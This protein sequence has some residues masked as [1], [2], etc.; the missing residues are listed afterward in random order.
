MEPVSTPERRPKRPFRRAVVVHG[1][2]VTQRIHT[3]L[4]AFKLALVVFVPACLT[5]PEEPRVPDAEAEPERAPRALAPEPAPVAVPVVPACPGA[6]RIAADGLI[7]DL[8]DGDA[9]VANAAGR[10]GY[11]W[12]AKA[13]HA[14]VT[15]PAGPSDGGAEGSKKAVRFA[16]KTDPK[17]EWGAAVGANFLESGGFY[18]ASKYAG[19]AFKIKASKPNTSVRVKLPDVSTIPDGGLCGTTCWNSFGKDLVVGAEWQD[20]VVKWSELAQQ[21]GWGNPRPPSVSVDQLKNVEW[22]VNQGV[23]FDVVIHDVRFVECG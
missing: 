1:G 21:P 9:R 13:D 15:T 20:V 23:E 14:N 4:A 2:I 17:D 22:A 10:S 5:D 8:E 19:I 3:V 11:W 7:D 18:D 16:G 12:I 6:T